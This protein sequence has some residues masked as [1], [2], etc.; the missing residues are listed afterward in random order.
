MMHH[1]EAEVRGNAE[2]E[3]SNLVRDGV[4]ASDGLIPK[5]G[6]LE[7]GRGQQKFQHMVGD[8]AGMSEEDVMAC[9]R[10]RDDAGRCDLVAE[11]SPEPVM[12]AVQ[13]MKHFLAP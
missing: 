3:W 5:P 6:A 12:K 11:I 4:S 9:S 13:G 2:L 1:S 7:P 10:D 8:F